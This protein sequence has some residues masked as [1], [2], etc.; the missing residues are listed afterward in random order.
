M[1]GRRSR[2]APLVLAVAAAMTVLLGFGALGHPAD[3]QSSTPSGPRALSLISQT[4]WVGE[5]GTF[6]VIVSTEGLPADAKIDG[7][8]YPRVTSRAG[9][10]ASTDVASLPADIFKV[11]RRPLTELTVP[12]TGTATVSVVVSP[13]DVGGNIAWIA[14]AGVYPF[15][16]RAYQGETIIAQVVT[17]L[18]RLA[19]AGTTSAASPLTVGVTVPL[20]ATAT[21]D[22]GGR[23]TLDAAGSS[24]LIDTI[25]AVTQAPSVPLTLLPS[26]ESLSLLASSTDAADAMALEDLRAPAARTVLATPYAPIDIGAWVSSGLGDQIDAQYDIGAETVGP[27]LG[28]QPN[29]RIAVLDRTVTPEGITSLVGLGTESVVV[30]STQLE[31]LRDA[32]ANANFAASF[33]LDAGPDIDPPAVVADDLTASR[34][35]PGGDPVLAGHLALA[36]LAMVQLASTQGAR[37][38]AVVVPTDAAPLALTTFLA[39]LA[40]PDGRVGSGSAGTALVRAATVDDL[41]KTVD[42]ATVTTGGRITTLTRHYE[43]DAPGDLGSYPREL[44]AASQSFEGLSSML[45]GNAD[46]TAPV[47]ALLLS[48]GA[49]Y[50]DESGRTAVL[51]AAGTAT[52]AVTDEI[53]VAPKQVVTLTS[54]SGQVPLNLE[55]RLS[56]PATVRIVMSSAK[57]DF[58]E[59]SVIEQVL[60]PNTT[61]PVSLQVET[62]ASGAFPLDVSVTSADGALP[63]AT[64]EY[65]V[66]STAVSGI[67]L[68]LSI[69]AGLFL[70]VWWAR[71]FRTARRAR[72]LVAADT[73]ALTP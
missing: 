51:G 6:Q 2:R 23:P 45:P 27:L 42:K 13:T 16:V 48:S 4:S 31:P 52:A 11:P 9:L 47:R 8:M 63:I 46:L 1:T 24:R 30:P 29:G 70:L 14:G 50:L 3:A 55:N 38:V 36:E 39:G 64:T 26:A 67:G 18:I 68:V 66:R 73:E 19:P 40:D 53:I 61:T 5:T 25:D 71:H 32:G 57:L 37:G 35:R 34:L 22:D 56:V 15:A 41:F 60:D 69:G 59:G 65:T 21:L 49:R 54:S 10:E 58:P 7:R 44:R 33:T 43:S 62:R 28:A 17:Q 20:S 12:G 72:Q